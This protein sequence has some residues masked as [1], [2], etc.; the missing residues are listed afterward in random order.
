MKRARY[1]ASNNLT[2]IA[3]SELQP[4]DKKAGASGYRTRDMHLYE[5]PWPKEILE[6]MPPDTEV[7][8]KVTLSYYIEP[9]PGEIGWQDRYRYASHGLRFELNSPTESKDEFVRRINVAAR[10]E[11]NGHP[12]TSSAS[13]HWLLGQV[14]NKGSI[15]SDVW[16]GSAQQLA[17]SNLIAV[18]P[19]V[20]W[21]RE[22]SHLGKW[23]QKTRYSLIVS[24][25]TPE[26]SVDIYTPVAIQLGVPV[27]VQIT[28]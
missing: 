12:G 10:D 27:P 3:Q 8:M 2:L 28:I 4:F 16:A 24:I 20:G 6:L 14:R 22:R 25:T 23:N 15:H 26:E 7:K 13:D 5:L 11:E 19:T 17:S 18:H 9:G 1:S 21:W